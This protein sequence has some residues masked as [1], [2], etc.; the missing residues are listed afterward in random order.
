MGWKF[1]LWEGIEIDYKF[2]IMEKFIFIT[3]DLSVSY[4][5][6]LH[7]SPLLIL[8]N[9]YIYGGYK[10]IIPLATEDFEFFPGRD[11]EWYNDY[12]LGLSYYFE[13]VSLTSE[14]H[15]FKETDSR[16]YFNQYSIGIQFHYNK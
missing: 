9:K 14:F 11:E 10:H 4:A 15:L 12:V 13:S 7:F 1:G 16:R 3:G 5:G 8:G 2:N 6:M